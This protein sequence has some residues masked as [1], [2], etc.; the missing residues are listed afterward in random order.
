MVKY[1]G[2]Q[3]GSLLFL[4]AVLGAGP[5]TS[6]DLNEARV[7]LPYSELRALLA[8]QAE[9]PAEKPKPPAEATLLAA[10]YSI[11]IKDD[12]VS[13][14]IDYEAQSFTDHWAVVP[15][16]GAATQIDEIEPAEA[17]LIMRDN[18][19]A[20][21]T[22]HV[23][24]QK[25]R[26]KFGAKLTRSAEGMHLHLP[27][28]AASINTL[29]V[30]GIP[31]KQKLRIAGATQI[32]ADKDRTAFRL[33]AVNQLDFDLAADEALTPP[34]PSP[35]K[36]ET[37]A[38]VELSDGRLNYT[39]HLT[40]NAERGSGLSMDLAFPQNVK[41]TSM[42]GPDLAEWQAK[43]ALN[44]NRLVHVGWQTRDVLRRQ[45]QIEY[46][47]PQPL[48]ASAWKLQ[49]PRL[50]EGEMDPPLFVIVPEPG[51][52]LTAVAPTAPPRQLPRWLA[53]QMV[54][55]NYRAFVGD[56][57]LTAKWL[58]LV[59]AARAVVE[60]AK[61]HM[62]IVVN[63][64][65]L[66]E[67]EYVIRHEGALPWKV[68]MPEGCD[69]LAC[70][71]DG[72]PVNPIDRGDHLLEL[73]LPGGKRVTTVTLSY[74]EKKP[75]FKPVSGQVALELPKTDLL[76]DKIDWELRIPEA[77]VIAAFEGNVE[78]DNGSAVENNSRIIQ[79]HK[80]LCKNERP[81]AELFY[82]KPQPNK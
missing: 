72:R 57:P 12:Q 28:C 18:H 11:A 10:R 53:D 73:S 38:L 69:L 46:N 31:E 20:L 78:S 82:E 41:I 62:R 63:G 74:T 14:V 29:F 45:L 33:P 71:I 49:S 58:P 42:T 54:G 51:L 43:G 66:N 32:S 25:F 47:F 7:T 9:K 75:P 80:Q 48:T 39:A 56:T 70:S 67:T 37:Q 65:L 36:L 6:P 76:V 16:F 30:T 26:I 35:W 22:D 5:E 15:L 19:Y 40:V 50:V 21:V 61:A 64:S 60:T 52:E 4:T 44:E 8:I 17:H 23:G 24:K 3:I 68:D 77:Y 13:G 59:E 27:I 81:S 2:G 1:I 34:I 55:K 79:L